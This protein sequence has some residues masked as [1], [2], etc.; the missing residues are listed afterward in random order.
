MY[1]KS[2]AILEL[3]NFSGI[4]ILGI[5]YGIND[6]VKFCYTDD[7]KGDG[8]TITAKIRYD[9]EG[10]SYFISYGHRYDIDEFIRTNS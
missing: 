7:E 3:T 5:E 2:I 4:K 10:K 8:R 6:K 1:K 9:D